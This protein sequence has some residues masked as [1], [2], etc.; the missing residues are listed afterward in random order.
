MTHKA[1]ILAGFILAC[2]IITACGVR[3]QG[4]KEAAR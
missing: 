1:G 2:H 3:I 4:L